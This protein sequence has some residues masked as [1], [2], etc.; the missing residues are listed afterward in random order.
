MNRLLF[1][2]L[3]LCFGA[4]LHAQVLP[5][6]GTHFTFAIPEGSDNLIDPNFPSSLSVVT[7]NIVSRFDGQGIVTSPSGYCQEF[8][9][10]ANKVTTVTLAYNLILLHDLGK[11]NKGILVRTSQPANITLHDFLDNA[12]EATQIFPDEALD[13]A[14]RISSWGIYNDPGED[15]HSQFVVTAT[16]DTT[17]VIIIP[18]VN[19]LGNHQAGVPINIRLNRGECYIVKAD[20]NGLPS[21]VSLTN[22]AVNATKPVSVMIGLSCAYN[23]LGHE[24]CNELLD[25]ILPKRV[26]GT[27]FYVAPL[28]DNGSVCTAVFTSAKPDFLVLASGGFSFPSTNGMAYVDLSRPQVFTTTEETQCFILTRGSDFEDEGDPSIVSVLPPEQYI[29]TMLWFTPDF[30]GKIQYVPSPFQDFVSVI[31][32]KASQSQILLDN[33]PLVSFGTPKDI[34]G[35][36]MTGI[37][38]PIGTGIHLLTSPVPVFAVVSGFADADGYSFLPGSIGDKIKID[39]GVAMLS[40]SSTKASTCRNFDVDI[41]TFVHSPDALSTFSI[42]ITYDPQVL[43]LVSTNL[44]HV[45][46]GGQWI[47]D[48]RTPGI[49]LITASCVR[50]FTDSGSLAILTF[51]AGSKPIKTTIT[52]DLKEF[53]G[54]INYKIFTASAQ[55][56]IPTV[57]VRDTLK[58]ILALDPTRTSSA[59]VVRTPVRIISAPAEPINELNLFVTYNHDLLVLDHADL[60][61]SVLGSNVSVTPIPLN[62]TT[63]QISIKLSPPFIFAKPGEVAELVFRS[64]VTDNLSDQIHVSSTLQNLRDC[65]LDILSDESSSLYIRNDSCGDPTVRAYMQ[66]KAF[67]ITSIIP[68]P[69]TNN[70]RVDFTRHLFTAEPIRIALI[71][72]LGNQIWTT[73]YQSSFT[74]ESVACEI[75]STIHSGDYLLRVSAMGS[76]ETKRVTIQR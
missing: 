3:I 62:S 65:P 22:S 36:P 5:R 42:T 13:T 12:G 69:T 73:E 10:A 49:I 1:A 75:P 61:N 44:A 67:A 7:L 25:E 26:V 72:L 20:I 39:T 38:A 40:I 32:P 17:D 9:F 56:D 59:N 70:F 50:P 11:S 63:D 35:T 16:H 58:A 37:V 74:D 6:S 45:A 28:R 30:T 53:G 54:E 60:T 52:A 4:Q 8:S 27:T 43:S 66:N 55:I 48:T 19:S 68:N 14:Y 24:S 76:T 47:A 71:D 15:N 23:P 18:S 51:T 21:D 31:Y 33:K 34:S 29:D 2:F 64:Y 57:V 46:Q 41:S